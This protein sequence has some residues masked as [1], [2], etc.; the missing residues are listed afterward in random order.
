MKNFQLDRPFSAVEQEVTTKYESTFKN[1]SLQIKV[2]W[3]R[4]KKNPQQYTF[5]NNTAVWMI[6]M[7]QFFKDEATPQKC[8]PFFNGDRTVLKAWW[9]WGEEKKAPFVIK[10]L[11]P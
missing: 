1:M 7:C 2:N 11:K 8:A 4:E 9:S 3:Q 5:S 6:F 10:D